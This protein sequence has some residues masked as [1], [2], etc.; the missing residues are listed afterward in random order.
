MNGTDLK[1]EAQVFCKAVKLTLAGNPQGMKMAQMLSKEP[2]YQS[3]KAFPFSIQIGIICKWVRDALVQQHDTSK[4]NVAWWVALATK[5]YEIAGNPRTFD[6]T[7]CALYVDYY[8]RFY[9]EF[10]PGYKL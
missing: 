1:T 3:I 6:E 8:T 10:T 5:A 9:E 4:K 7:Y 2:N